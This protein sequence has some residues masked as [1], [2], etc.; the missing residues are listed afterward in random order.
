MSQDLSS[1]GI[2]AL[3]ARRAVGGF[4]GRVRYAWRRS[5]HLRVVLTTLVLS[6]TV[7]AVLGYVLMTRVTT[8]LLDAST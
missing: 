5:L 4:F 3:R 6:A 7:V 8:G 2:T 1:L